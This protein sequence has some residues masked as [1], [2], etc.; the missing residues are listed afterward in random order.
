MGQVRKLD[1]KHG[2]LIYYGQAASAAFWDNYW[3]PH[4]VAPLP[5]EADTVFCPILP[6]YVSSGGTILEA[7]CGPCGIVRALDAI[8]YRTIGLDFAQNTL[9]QN[10][11]LYPDMSLV[12]GDVWTLPFRDEVFDACISGGVIEHFWSGYSG[13][14]SE[15]AR[16]LKKGGYVFLTF[17]NMSPLRRIK[18]VLGCYEEDNE[19]GDVQSFYQYVFDA[20]NVRRD[21]ENFGFE[22]LEERRLDGIKGWKD[23]IVFGRAWMQGV[24]DGAIRCHYRNILD[25]MLRKVAGHLVM[26]VLRKV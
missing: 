9:R 21:M 17:P 24:Y 8:G 23:E 2:R 16:V 10:H 1:V 26:L 22:L 6:K 5:P 12:V 14:I 13:I 19:G 20:R 15:M 11:L 25:R 3:Q 7:G 18:A 4:T